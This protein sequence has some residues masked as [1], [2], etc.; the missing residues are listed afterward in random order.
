[1]E[2]Y[3]FQP[4]VQNFHQRR[5]GILM[6]SYIDLSFKIIRKFIGPELSDTNLSDIVYGSY[7]SFGLD[8]FCPTKHVEK[9]QYLLE[10]FHGPTLAFKD[11]AMQ[12]IGNLFEFYL[13]ADN[14]R[15][16]IVTATSGD[17][18]AAAVELLKEKR[19]WSYL[20]FFHKEGYVATLTNDNN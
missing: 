11:F 14:K 16:T 3:I 15:L 7:L 19:E 1:M 5:L 8:D 9:N 20:Y 6:A 2:G 18:G 13:K 4:L 12:F 10:L 17:T